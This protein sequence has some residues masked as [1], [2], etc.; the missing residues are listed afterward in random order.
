MRLKLTDTRVAPDGKTCISTTTRTASPRGPC[1]K[2]KTL[3]VSNTTHSQ[4]SANGT[5]VI[6][7]VKDLTPDGKRQV[8][9]VDAS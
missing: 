5:P 9:Q 4:V 6:K 8:D 2:T 1:E 3:P 7:E